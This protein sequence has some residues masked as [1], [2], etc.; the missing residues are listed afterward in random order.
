MFE[1]YTRIQVQIFMIIIIY[2]T[3]KNTHYPVWK[4][5]IMI[6]CP[7]IMLYSFIHGSLKSVHAVLKFI[8]MLIIKSDKCFSIFASLSSTYALH[9]I[10]CYL[11]RLKVRYRPWQEES[12]SSRKTLNRQ[13]TDYSQPLRSLRKH[14]RLLMR[15]KGRH[16]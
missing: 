2:I 9:T 4:A 8:Q 11:C 5:Q 16:E 12:V 1:W 6:D 7:S 3:N 14:P 10:L 13:R 15:A